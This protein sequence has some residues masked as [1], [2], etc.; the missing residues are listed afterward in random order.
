MSKF[1]K[2][3]YFLLFVALLLHPHL[4]PD[5][6][7]FLPRAYAESVF[8]SFIVGVGFLVYYFHKKDIQKRERQKQELLQKA[9]SLNQELVSSLKY[10]GS[11]NRRF[12]LLNDLT[13]ELL[14]SVQHTNKGRKELFQKLLSIAA[15]SV[16]KTYW[17]SL[18]FVHRHKKQM[19]KEFIY[20]DR[21]ENPPV[22]E[23][24]VVINSSDVESPIE[25]RLIL[26]KVPETAREHRTLQ[27]ITDQAQLFYKYLY[28]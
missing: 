13:S 21:E 22:A 20:K 18:K 2:I 19:I 8:T 11:V 28:T 9:N 12:S 10:I 16:A 24:V 17:G 5:H 4:I 1:T 7:R 15:V 27:I 25:C 14:A 3:I 26:P 23:E 6:I